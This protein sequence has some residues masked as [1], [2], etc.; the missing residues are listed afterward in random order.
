MTN[1]V[2]FKFEIESGREVQ[3][4]YWKSRA[5]KDDN[6]GTCKKKASSK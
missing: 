4:L 3:H 6:S 5:I 1:Q 2:Q